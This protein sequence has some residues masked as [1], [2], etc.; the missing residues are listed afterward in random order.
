MPYYYEKV[1]SDFDLKNLRDSFLEVYDTYQEECAE[2]MGEIFK[3][4]KF[5]Q[6]SFFGK[7]KLKKFDKNGISQ[8]K[9][10]YFTKIIPQFCKFTR[11]MPLCNTPL[12]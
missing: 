4:P 3:D 7:R 12:S 1:Y 9:I 10:S 2:E 8:R 5:D 6:Y 11:L